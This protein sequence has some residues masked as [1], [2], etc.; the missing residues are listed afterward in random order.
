TLVVDAEGDL[1]IDAHHT[2]EDTGIVLGRAL[3]AALGEKVGIERMGECSVPMDEALVRAV[4]DLGGRSYVSFHVDV[5]G[6]YSP[7]IDLTVLEGFWKAVCDGAGMNLHVDMLRGRD[8]HH[9]VEATFKACGRALRAATRPD[10]TARVPTTKEL[11][12]G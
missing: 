2:V 3:K 12:D 4:V 6:T 7:V 10:G 8:Y 5:P 11:F 1:H 9:V